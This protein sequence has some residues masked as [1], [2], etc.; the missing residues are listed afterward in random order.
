MKRRLS[1]ER[2]RQAPRGCLESSGTG[3][4]VDKSAVCSWQ[5]GKS[6]IMCAMCAR[7][8]L[9]P[10]CST[11]TSPP[12]LPKESGNFPMQTSMP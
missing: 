10:S 8:V 11:G 3:S 9:G 5:K 1:W 7:G 4:T 12:G 2:Q 6:C